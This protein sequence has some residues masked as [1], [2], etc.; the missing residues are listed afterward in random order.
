M[1]KCQENVEKSELDLSSIDINDITSFLIKSGFIKKCIFSKNQL[2]ILNY[3]YTYI[4]HLCNILLF[5]EK[6][7]VNEIIEDNKNLISS[8]NKLFNIDSSLEEIYNQYIYFTKESISL[9]T[10]INW[11]ILLDIII[12]YFNDSLNFGNGKVFLN[13]MKNKIDIFDI[14]SIYS[15]NPNNK[16]YID[17]LNLLYKNLEKQPTYMGKIVKS[18]LIITIYLLSLENQIKINKDIPNISVLL[19]YFELYNKIYVSNIYFSLLLYIEIIIIINIYLYSNKNKKNYFEYN[20]SFRN[21]KIYRNLELTETSISFFSPQKRPFNKKTINYSTSVFNNI[22]R[23]EDNILNFYIF[24]NEIAPLVY[25]TSTKIFMF[26]NY[27]KLYAFFYLNKNKIKLNMNLTIENIQELIKKINNNKLLDEE[28]QKIENPPKTA[29]EIRDGPFAPNNEFAENLKNYIKVNKKLKNSINNEVQKRIIEDN[30]NINNNCKKALFPNLNLI[31]DIQ[32]QKINLFGLKFMN[33]NNLS[34]CFNNFNIDQLL[35]KLIN[36]MDLSHIKKINT[37]YIDFILNSNICY[38][39]E[40]I[41]A[42]TNQNN[43]KEKENDIT[44]TSIMLT[45]RCIPKNNIL[46][47]YKKDTLLIDSLSIDDFFDEC[48]ILSYFLDFYSHIEA[49]KLPKI[50]QIK[51]NTFK[52]NISQKTKTLQIYFNFSNIKEKKLFQYLKES[53]GMLLFIQK[54]QNIIHNLKEYKLYHITIRVSQTNFRSSQLN[55]YFTFITHKIVDYIEEIKMN[56]III[57]ETQL[58]NYNPNMKVYLKDIYLKKKYQ[59]LN[60][61]TIIQSCSFFNKIKVLLEHVNDFVDEWDLIVLSDNEK[62]IKLLRT[63]DDNKLFFFITKEN[64]NNEKTNKYFLTTV[65]DNK[66]K[67]AKKEKNEKKEKNVKNNGKSKSYEY[68]NIIMYVRNS[69]DDLL[70]II[71]TMQL[72]VINKNSILDYKTNI[73]CDR[74]FFEQK[75][76]M[77]SKMQQLQMN[78]SNLI[79]DF[80]FISKK[81]GPINNNYIKI[82]KHKDYRISKEFKDNKNIKDIKESENNSNE[83]YNY[84][85]FIGDDY[86]GILN[87]HQYD[88]N[89]DSQ[90]NYNQLIYE[91]LSV[92]SSCLELIYFLLKSKNIFILR[93]VYIIR[94]KNEL[95]YSWEFKNGNIFIKKVKDFTSL[96]TLNIKNCIPLFCFL[97]KTEKNNNNIFEGNDDNFYDIFIR[98]FLNLNKV[99]KNQ[100]LN[101]EFLKKVYKNIFKECSFELVAFSYEAFLFFNDFFIRNDYLTIT[102]GEKFEKCII[103]PSEGYFNKTNYNKILSLFNSKDNN[104]T[105]IVKNL[106]IFNF[107]IDYNYIFKNKSNILFGF[108]KLYYFI[109]E[110]N[111]YIFNNIQYEF[112]QKKDALKK[113]FEEKIKNINSRKNINKYINK[114]QQ[115]TFGN[116]GSEINSNENEGTILTFNSPIELYNLIVNDYIKE[117]MIIRTQKNELNVFQAEDRNQ[118]NKIG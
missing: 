4:E 84:D 17:K 54:Y 106:N 61:K 53:K 47:Q 15:D 62:D 45:P 113:K 96:F 35:I 3:N 27:L 26:Q 116:L 8:I 83:Y 36:T 91:Y 85:F 42:F 101:I 65:N 88:I 108:S 51:L 34:V 117:K 90:N 93:F 86:V 105:L 97:S 95:Y 82:K 31:N 103:I 56:K 76:L 1:K 7:E 44:D 5:D 28:L 107:G 70:K 46:E 39:Q 49:K 38:F 57:Y 30:N 43:N 109:S 52:C 16:K 94:T 23:F 71:N 22:C 74:F 21:N 9:N 81:I 68:L 75:I 2:L 20:P 14:N 77:D 24:D 104:K 63:F 59:I 118:E 67:N 6:L 19:N 98:L 13:L 111:N 115:L 87:N 55:Y 29:R 50:I 66:N 110:Y 99:V 92:L 18:D 72:L 69:N 12:T 79:D 89:I 78:I 41:F 60:L 114:I 32:T 64:D 112:K 73:I 58:N 11:L 80:F 102:N 100:E 25:D 40:S 33:K 10:F 37:N 48:A